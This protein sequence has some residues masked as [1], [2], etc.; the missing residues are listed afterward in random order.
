MLETIIDNVVHARLDYWQ[1]YKKE[2]AT[3]QTFAMN[4]T[5]GY[6]QRID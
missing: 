1:K 4:V 2:L 3:I 6:R 5:K